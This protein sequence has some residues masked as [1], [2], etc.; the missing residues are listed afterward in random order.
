[1]LAK[2]FLLVMISSFS[3]W[4]LGQFIVPGKV[5]TLELG[6]ETAKKF[7]VLRIEGNIMPPLAEEFELAISQ[8]PAGRRVLLEFQSPGGMNT[9]GNKII[10]SIKKARESLTID[11]F[12]DNGAICASMCIPLFMQG[13]QRIAGE[14]STFMFHGAAPWYTNI[15]T[16]SVTKEY[17]DSLI[18]AGAS[19]EWLQT[20]WDLGVFSEPMEYWVNGEELFSEKTGIVT[21]LKPK[22]IKHEPKTAPFDPQLGPK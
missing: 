11:S 19:E 1:M 4:A 14:R 16:V 13:R 7:A 21:H 3:P 15:P 10:E 20:L 18:A 22:V 2:F 12:V 8:F 9:E 6:E 5:I 17:T